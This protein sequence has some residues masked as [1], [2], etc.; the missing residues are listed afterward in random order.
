MASVQTDM[1]NFAPKPRRIETEDERA[2]R[3]EE[4]ATVA[5][6]AAKAEEDAMDAAVRR[7]IALHGA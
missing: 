3:R 2:A 4:L 7:S 1:E 5:A 6:S